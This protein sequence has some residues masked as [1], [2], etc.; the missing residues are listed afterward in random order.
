MNVQFAEVMTGC[1][2]RDKQVYRS[3]FVNGEGEK[4]PEGLVEGDMVFDERATGVRQG[5]VADILLQSGRVMSRTIKDG[6][7]DRPQRRLS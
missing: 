7:N 3:E 2:Q 6:L 1:L 4:T 5:R